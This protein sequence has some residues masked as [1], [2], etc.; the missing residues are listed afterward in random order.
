MTRFWAAGITGALAA[1]ASAATPYFP[2]TVVQLT[3]AD[4]PPPYATESVNNG[5]R[6]VTVLRDAD[7]N[8]EPEVR[9][10]F[11]ENLN[12]PFGLAFLP[13]YLYIAN[14]DSVVRVPYADGDLATT[15]EPE[16]I[17]DD[18]PGHGYNQHWTRNLAL[19]PSGEWIYCSVGS[20]TNADVEEPPRA[21]IIRF[22]PDGSSEEV[23]ASGLRN[24]VGIGFHPTTHQ[25]WAAVNERDGL[26]DELV[27]D[28]FTHVEQ[29]AFYGW[30]YSYIG[31]NRD[32]RIDNGP[33]SLIQS[34]VVP[35]LLITSHSAA[36]G[37]VFYTGEMFPQEV[38]RDAFI[39]LHGS[40]NRSARTGFSIIRVPMD[41]EGHPLGWYE[42][43][44]RGWMNDP[45]DRR[46]WGRPVDLAIDQA[47]AL[48]LTD[49]GGNKVW[50]VTYQSA[51]GE[52][53]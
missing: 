36:L 8:G 12:Q 50:R 39:A 10:T 31:S 14:T 17:I 16:T 1:A 32:P 49:D 53:Q 47:G 22:H 41:E 27:P 9:E 37:Y 44:L 48:L 5:P 33:E 2:D 46:V 43:F 34:A 19:D 40:W 29:G 7:H 42:H 38:R 45:S 24:A 23:F 28:Y 35:D 11:L 18:I 3:P 6:V 52:A 26:G 4:L 20:A 51:S 30:P 15:A 13:G 25:L 21:C